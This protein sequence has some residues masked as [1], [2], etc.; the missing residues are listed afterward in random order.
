MCRPFA[1]LTLLKNLTAVVRGRE[2]GGMLFQPL[3]EDEIESTEGPEAHHCGAVGAIETAGA[4]GPED[5]ADRI[6]VV[7]VLKRAHV[8]LDLPPLLD[9]I[10]WYENATGHSL[11]KHASHQVREGRPLLQPRVIGS[12]TLEKLVAAKV[13][14]SGRDRTRDMDRETAV[15]ATNPLFSQSILHDPLDDL[16][17][18][19]GIRTIELLDL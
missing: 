3:V 8:G 13:E 12:A 2:I 5:L 15:Q 19:Y 14:R 17:T 16:T 11:R 7:C 6:E 4:L 9:N 18:G 1:R 10:D